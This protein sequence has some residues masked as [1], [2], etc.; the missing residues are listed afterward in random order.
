MINTK[1]VIAKFREKIKKVLFMFFDKN[2][3]QRFLK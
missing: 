3:D 1:I 2:L